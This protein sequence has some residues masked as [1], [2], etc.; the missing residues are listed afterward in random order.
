MVDGSVGRLSNDIVDD[1]LKGLARWLRKH[2][3]YAELEAELRVKRPPLPE[4]LKE[5]R[6]RRIHRPLMR[7]VA[8]DI[9]FPMVP[10][11][12]LVLFAYMY[13]VRGGFLDGWEGRCFCVLHAWHEYLINAL[14]WESQQASKGALR[15]RTSQAILS[16]HSDLL[17]GAGKL[18]KRLV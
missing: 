18:L 6:Q 3:W 8:K 13:L 11:K 16:I 17:A 2:A 5:I 10:F 7:A 4:R 1:D 14:L 12:P 15:G 9:V